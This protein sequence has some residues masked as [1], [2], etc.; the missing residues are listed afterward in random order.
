MLQ[1]LVGRSSCS[2]DC[3]G[4]DLR[5]RK[6]KVDSKIVFNYLSFGILLAFCSMSN[7]HHSKLTIHHQMHHTLRHMWLVQTFNFLWLSKLLQ[8]SDEIADSS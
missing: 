6:S 4:W 5:W 2:A 8:T 3:W 1:S 7:L